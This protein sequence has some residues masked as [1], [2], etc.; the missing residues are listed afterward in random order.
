MFRRIPSCVC[1]GYVVCS[2]GGLHNCEGSDAANPRPIKVRN[3][4]PGRNGDC[5]MEAKCTDEVPINYVKI[6]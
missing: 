5:K 1:S 3:L 4:W 2:F 6:I